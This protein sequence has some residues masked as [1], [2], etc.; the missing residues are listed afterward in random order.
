MCCFEGGEQ[1]FE[2]IPLAA[3]VVYTYCDSLATSPAQL[4]LGERKV[5]PDPTVRHDLVTATW[6]TRDVSGS[7]YVIKGDVVQEKRS[8]AREGKYESRFALILDCPFRVNCLS[9][10]CWHYPKGGQEPSR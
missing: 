2:S 10:G 6:E 7:H 1:K 5:A 9:H 4:L 8:W 3:I